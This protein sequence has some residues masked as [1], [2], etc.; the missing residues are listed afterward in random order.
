MKPPDLRSMKRHTIPFLL[1]LG[2]WVLLT[3][4]R[5]PES[6][7]IGILVAMGVTVFS[8]RILFTEAEMPLYRLRHLLM[9]LTYLPLL[10]VE[11]VKSNIDVARVVL[12][13]IMP[14]QPQ[15]IKVPIRIRNEVNRVI[16]GNSITL[17]PGTLTVDITDEYFLVHALTRNAADTMQGNLM[18]RW[19]K[20]MD[21][22][23]EP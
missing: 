15:L 9:F 14:I 4:N 23:L 19:V 22:G 21:E 5:T 16:L 13:P 1:L 12:S 6:F 10:L 2:F 18:I 7:S 11:I 8:R 3:P 20:K 17:T